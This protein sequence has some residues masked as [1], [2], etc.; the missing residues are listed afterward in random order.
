MEKAENKNKMAALSEA[1]ST[2]VEPSLFGVE[3]GREEDTV[4]ISNKK[5]FVNTLKVLR[6][7]LMS[8][9]FCQ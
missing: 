6:C 1:V 8:G 7:Y 3:S 9:L 2:S 5:Y 4:I